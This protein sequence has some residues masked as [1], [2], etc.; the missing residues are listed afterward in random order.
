MSR[1]LLLLGE[2]L[3]STTG[4]NGG[5]VHTWSDSVRTVVK[6]AHP[7]KANALTQNKNLLKATANYLPQITRA[8]HSA[9]RAQQRSSSVLSFGICN[10][11]ASTCVLWAS[12]CVLWA[13]T[14][15][16]W[17]ST[18]VLWA[19]TCVV[20]A[21]TCVVWASTC[22]VWKSI[23]V[24][25]VEWRVAL[26]NAVAQRRTKD[27]TAL[28]ARA[29]GVFASFPSLAV[30]KSGVALTFPITLQ[31][32]LCASDRFFTSSASLL[33]PSLKLQKPLKNNHTPHTHH[34]KF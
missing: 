32:R 18:C 31:S 29:V 34:A 26:C 20:W 12:T 10:S 25:P 19:S 9:P 8:P 15:V 22:V 13:S 4:R 6:S 1:L 7:Q 5:S 3:S 16:L 21:S 23:C 17:A 28:E 24:S 11:S 30:I 33:D 27:D 2:R 14:C